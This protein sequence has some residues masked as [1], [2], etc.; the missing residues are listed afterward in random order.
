MYYVYILKNLKYTKYY[1]GSTSDIEKRVKYHNEGRQRWTSRF[2]PW[3]LVYKK[4]FST[5][6]EALLYEK[7]LKKKKSKKYLEWLVENQN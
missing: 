3:E 2:I 7:L 5:K 1:I 6:T 4:E